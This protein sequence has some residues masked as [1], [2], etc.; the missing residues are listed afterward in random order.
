MSAEIRISVVIACYQQARELDLTLASFLQ[1]S[2]DPRTYELIVVDDHSATAEA[3]EVVRRARLSHPQAQLYYVSNWRGDGGRYGA[4]AVVKNAGIRI[5][6]GDIVFFN[7][8]EIVQAGETLEYIVRTLDASE[9]PLCLR[10]VVLDLPYEDLAGSTPSSRAEIHDRTDRARERVATA[11]HAG[12]AAVSRSLLNRVG[13]IDERFDYWGKEDLDLA[14]RLKRAGAVYRYDQALK[15]FHVSHPKNHLKEGDY[16]RMQ[17]LLE[18]NDQAQVIEVN[19]G[20][21]W[22]VLGRMPSHRMQA[23]VAVEVRTTGPLEPLARVLEELVYGEDAA[24]REAILL[25][26]EQRRSELQDWL[27]ARWPH[28]PIVAYDRQDTA[29]LMHR[30]LR[31]THADHLAWLPSGAPFTAL[32]AASA[33]QQGADIV[34]WVG[35]AAAPEKTARPHPTACCGWIA[36]CGAIDADV[37]WGLPSGW[38]LRAFAQSAGAGGRRLVWAS[39]PVCQPSPA[40]ACMGSPAITACSSVLAVV[41]HYRCESWLPACLHSLVT[42]T[43]PPDAIAVLHDGPEPPVHLLEQFPSVALYR[44]VDRVGPYAL[45]QSLV[46]LTRFDAVLFQDADDWSSRDRLALLLAEA[47]RTGADLIGSQEIRVDEIFGRVYATC[48]PLD[49]NRALSIGPGH[50]L[51]HPTSLISTRLLARLGGFATGLRFGADTE[52]LLRAG[53][54]ARI[55]NLDVAAYFR[56]H[57]TSSLTTDPETGLDSP[58]RHALLAEVK[59]RANQNRGLCDIG[60]VPNLS[61]LVRSESISLIHLSGP[62]LMSCRHSLNHQQFSF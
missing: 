25:C 8:S 43:R 17:A 16:R 20:R 52:M 1:Q 26:D 59:A 45:V 33:L 19:L 11:D 41:P 49:A 5:A 27:R 3:R 23:S 28:V 62:A 53:F 48:Y 31:H 40:A 42:Q 37:D 9:R 30:V 56:R 47:E 13:G 32:S 6:R 60:R 39:A 44:T 29:M 61:P 57:R 50:P 12:L 21:G 18:E 24:L 7:N 58:A 34:P 46:D 36:Q 35:A 2:L 55:V 22:G 14:A 51:L 10:G 4:S 38:A 15:S 54:V